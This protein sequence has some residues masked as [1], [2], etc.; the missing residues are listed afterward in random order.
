WSVVSGPVWVRPNLPSYAAAAQERG[1]PALPQLPQQ[2]ALPQ[3]PQQPSA[4]APAAAKPPF[5]T[6]LRFSRPH[7][8]LKVARGVQSAQVIR[9]HVR[10]LRQ[11]QHGAVAPQLGGEQF[12]RTIHPR[13]AADSSGVAKGPPNEYEAC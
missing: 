1:S 2:P 4:A 5:P 8:A 3:L 7:E 13:L 9:A 6:S 11:S 12:N 10:R